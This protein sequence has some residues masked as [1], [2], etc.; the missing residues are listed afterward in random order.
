MTGYTSVNDG[1]IQSRDKI[2]RPGDHAEQNEGG[3]GQ[4]DAGSGEVATLKSAVVTDAFLHAEHGHQ[5]TDDG[6]DS[7][8]VIEHQG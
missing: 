6:V 2:F 3:T 7:V 5:H 8:H 1:P 4:G